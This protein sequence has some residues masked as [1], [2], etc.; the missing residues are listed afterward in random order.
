MINSPKKRYT[1]NYINEIIAVY[2]KNYFFFLQKYT[3]ASSTKMKINMI[4][5]LCLLMM[6][7]YCILC[8][9]ENLNLADQVYGILL[10]IHDK[11]R[12]LAISW[13]T[14]HIQHTHQN[15][16]M[17]LVFMLQSLTKKIILFCCCCLCMRN[18]NEHI[19][20]KINVCFVKLVIW[21]NTHI[22]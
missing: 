20:V 21:N 18:A 2:P 11:C 12:P 8:T 5:V 14:F 19:A 3:K 1:Q 9:Y 17:I 7:V 22:A 15:V 4:P 10:V 13:P 6:E 16:Q